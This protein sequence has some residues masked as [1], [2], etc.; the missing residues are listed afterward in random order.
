[1][2][3]LRWVA[4]ML[5][6]RVPYAGPPDDSVFEDSAPSFAASPVFVAGHPKSGTTLVQNLLDGHPQLFDLPG[7]SNHFA[8]FLP[9]F[10]DRPRLSLVEAAQEKWIRQLISPTGLPPFWTLGRPSEERADPYERLTV[11]LFHLAERRP[12][13]DLL[14]V[15]AAA[16]C[17][18][19]TE[20]GVVS[21]RPRYWVEKTPG[22]ELHVDEILALY[23]AARFVHVVRDPRS[24]AAALEH[25]QHAAGYVPSVV[26]TSTNLRRSF[27]AADANLRRLGA[28]RYLVVRYEDLIAEPATVMA[29][30]AEFLEIELSDSLLTPTSGGTEATSNSA[31]PD[32]RVQGRIGDRREE[33]WRAELDEGSLRVVAAVTGDVARR[34]GYELPRS[35]RGRVL[36]GLQLRRAASGARRRL[37]SAARLGKG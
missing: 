15:I 20:Q 24:V 5:R 4:A 32:L 2:A 21:A 23:P 9:R 33:R 11:W 22:N 29:S 30:V 18:V 16:A 7:D 27:R 26:A 25:I 14:G 10:R 37:G 13:L 36:A 31:W 17:A 3:A 34:W 28:G 12:D 1:V 8:G 6:T 19:R 35:G